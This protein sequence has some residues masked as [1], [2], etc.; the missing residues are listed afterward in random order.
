MPIFNAG[1]ADV[2]VVK[3]QQLPSIEAVAGMRIFN[4]GN[5]VHV[6]HRAQPTVS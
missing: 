4:P 1:M 3:N 6:P 2:E 5:I